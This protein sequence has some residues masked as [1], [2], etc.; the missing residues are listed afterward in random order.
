MAVFKG[1]MVAAA[2]Q[3]LEIDDPDSKITQLKGMSKDERL[4]FIIDIAN[5]V[6]DKC[7]IVSDALLNKKCNR[8]KGWSAQLLTCTLPLCCSMLECTDAWEHG[9]GERITLCWRVFL[10]NFCAN[11]RTKY[12]L[13]ALTLQFQLATLSPSLVNL[14]TVY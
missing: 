14:G 9:D 3:E 10:L 11:G 12:A 1:Y 5:Q 13:E 4:S 2:W 7:G 6:V 8:Y